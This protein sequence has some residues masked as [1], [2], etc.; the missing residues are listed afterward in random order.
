MMCWW[1]AT[2]PPGQ[3]GAANFDGDSGFDIDFDFPPR[4][5]AG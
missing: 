3:D 5:E 4:E 2:Q 1:I